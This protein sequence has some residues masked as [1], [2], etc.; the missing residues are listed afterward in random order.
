MGKARRSNLWSRITILV[1][2]V[3]IGSSAALSKTIHVKVGGTGDGSSW[4]NAYGN[5]QTALDDAEPND[6][7]WVAQGTYKPTQLFDPCDPR[8]ATFQMK[9]GVGIYGGFSSVGDPNWEH[10]D[11]EEYETVLSGDLLGDD[12]DVDVVPVVVGGLLATPLVH[13]LCHL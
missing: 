7:I 1:A 10:R 13:S 9:N 4:S 11:W 8:S 12:R 3:L 2:V 6:S 5:L